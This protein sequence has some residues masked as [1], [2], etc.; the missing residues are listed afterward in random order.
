MARITNLNLSKTTEAS[1][2]TTIVNYSNDQEAKAAKLYR[3]YYDTL[4]EGLLRDGLTIAEVS[5][6]IKIP[7]A[8][9]QVWIKYI[10][11]F[12]EAVDRGCEA[13]LYKVEAALV[14]VSCGFTTSEE[15]EETKVDFNGVS[16]VKK[17]I[18]REVAPNIQA[19][20]YYL[21]NRS[22]NKWKNK[23]TVETTQKL[24][25][26]LDEFL[27]LD[28]EKDKQNIN[29]NSETGSYGFEDPE[30]FMTKG[31]TIPIYAEDVEM[32]I[33]LNTIINEDLDKE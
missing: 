28:E 3:S 7:L 26:M 31:E 11:T 16:T 23:M 15:T 10:K 30:N 1:P 25:S 24:G 29:I 27:G 5:T 9:L 20:Q 13:V 18:T 21:N 8:V 22:P 2:T 19:I 32:P 4:V 6:R 12:K 33:N 17:K 14:K